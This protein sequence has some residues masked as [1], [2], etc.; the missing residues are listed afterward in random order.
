MEG[1]VLIDSRARRIARIEGT[2]F[3]DVTFGWGIFGRLDRGGHFRIQ[4]TDA[5][6][7][8]WAITE[9]S[10]Q[11][12]GTILLVKSL[13]V[14]SDE[15]FSDFRRLPDDVPFAQAVDLLHTEQAKLAQ[16]VR[17]PQ[18]TEASRNSQ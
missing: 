5:G 1:F 17:S 16:S 8:N 6:E 13:N 18:P 15:V 7:G 3:K 2:L 10:L 9:M 11:I 12:K 14:I 4:Q